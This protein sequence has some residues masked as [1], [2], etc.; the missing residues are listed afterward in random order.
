MIEKCVDKYGQIWLVTYFHKQ[1]F[2]GTQLCSPFHVCIAFGCFCAT[3]AGLSGL[4][5]WLS[6][7]EYACQCRR[8]GFDP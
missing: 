4:P 5:R 1:R 7:E 2:V 8:L 3:P 6:G